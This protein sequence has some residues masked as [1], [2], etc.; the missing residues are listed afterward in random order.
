MEQK[1]LLDTL[2]KMKTALEASITEKAKAEIAEQIKEMKAANDK[3]I[4]DAKKLTDGD[5]AGI[6]AIND[7]LEEMKAENAALLKGFNLLQ[8]RV[9][10]TNLAQDE[11]KSWGATVAEVVDQKHDDIQKYLRKETNSLSLEIKAVAD[12]S[13]ANVTGGSVWGAQYRNGII[14]SPNTKVHARDFL[15]VVGAG[16]GTDYY[17]MKENGQGEGAPAFTSEKQVADATNVATGLKP[18]FDVDL[19]E[20]SVKFETLAGIMIA[21]NKSLKNIP[22]FLRYLNTKIPQ[23]MLDVETNNIFYGTGT[24]PIIKGILT[25]GNFTA[26]TSSA[27][28]LVE[29]IIDDLSLLEDTNK[30]MATGIALRPADYYS[31]F[32]NKAAGSGEYDLPQGLTF[33]GGVLYILGVPVGTTTGLTAGDY[34][35]GDFREGAELLIQETMKIEFFNQHASLAATNQQLIRAEETIALPVYGSEYFIK[36][37]VPT[38]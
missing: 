33:V 28:V 2:E 27:T 25:S 21:S 8:T 3:L 26:S 23:K 10:S 30:R 15:S 6:K 12:V 38:P 7:Q 9:K 31:F 17:F 34:I 4:E 14:M 37:A 13:T 5:A 1:E 29:S 20:S 35:V 11:K 16:P 22:D 36:G 19:V 18:S 32:K 24:S